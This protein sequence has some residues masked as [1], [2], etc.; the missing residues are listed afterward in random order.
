M[1]R[2]V[3][4]AAAVALGL[5]LAPISFDSAFAERRIALVIGNSAYENAAPLPN[6]TK[7]AQAMAEKFKQAGFAVISAHYDLGNLQF[8]RVIRQFEDAA[9]DADIVVVFYAGHGI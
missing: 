4:S 8:K 9:T 6:P 2:L 3:P 5:L 7:D 1:N